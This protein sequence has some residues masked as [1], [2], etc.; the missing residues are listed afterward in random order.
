MPAP[1][2]TRRRR[3]DLVR[4]PHRCDRADQGARRGSLR[5]L[6]EP[7]QCELRATGLVG[8]RGRGDEDLRAGHRRLAE[9]RRFTDERQHRHRRVDVAAG[10]ERPRPRDPRH[11]RLVLGSGGG[12]GI[13]HHEN[14]APP[15][16]GLIEAHRPR[17][18][19]AGQG[20]GCREASVL[21]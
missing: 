1:L 15:S 6:V 17:G 16:H 14:A 20:R 11:L 18:I 5:S 4:R 13:E 2:R 10:C 19:T 9:K 12:A 21:R 3:A 8:G 7:S